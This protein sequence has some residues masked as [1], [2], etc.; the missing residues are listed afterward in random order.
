M[1]LKKLFKKKKATQPAVAE[2]P[3]L[4]RRREN[5]HSTIRAGRTIGEKREKLETANERAALH[6]K[7]KQAK[8]RRIV[9]TI[10]GFIGLIVLL[11]LLF[12]NFSLPQNQPTSEDEPET[13][14]PTISI[15]DEGNT[16]AISG[17]MK[18]YVGRAERDLR[19]LG[20]IPV[21]AVI[22]AGAIREVDFYLENPN[23]YVKMVLD[24][25]TSVSVEDADRVIRHLS[26]NGIEG[27]TYIDVRI[28]G[29]AYWK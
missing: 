1:E 21:K 18:S 25:E 5:R 28:E 2:P 29:K 23:I 13:Y 12:K 7:A 20:Y 10:I 19:E 8:T 6:K 4:V 9:F 24:R 17:R 11:V 15:V 27:Y 22:P 26:A 3:R 14:N 16:G